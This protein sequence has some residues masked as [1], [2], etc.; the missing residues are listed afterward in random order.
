MVLLAESDPYSDTIA[1]QLPS[2]VGGIRIRYQTVDKSVLIQ[3]LL[4]GSFDAALIK[5]EATHHAPQ[6]WSAFFTPGN[7]YAAFGT[8]IAGMGMIDLSTA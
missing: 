8:P 6:F 7:P 1:A 4:K 3:S 5:I 2:S